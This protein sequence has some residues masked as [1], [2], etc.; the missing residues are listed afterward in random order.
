MRI[1]A[2]LVLFTALAATVDSSPANEAREQ[3]AD[4]RASVVAAFKALLAAGES[5]D[6]E[7]YLEAITD[8]AVMMYSGQPSVV[9]RKAVE[10]FIVDFF[11]RFDFRFDPW[12]SEEVVVSGN[13]AFHR[14]SGVATITPK[15]GGEPV[16][17]DRKYIDILRN[18]RGSWKV[19]HH[20]YNTNR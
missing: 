13:W 20:I 12:Q 11:D 18:E 9:G 8:D 2:T 3:S 16:V 7:G 1:L 19:S 17:R 6:A 5:G 14:Y 10:A 4:P 15:E